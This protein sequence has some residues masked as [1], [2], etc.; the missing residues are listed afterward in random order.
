MSHIIIRLTE[1]EAE[2]L[3][4]AVNGH[5]AGGEVALESGIYSD[6]YVMEAADRAADKIAAAM[7]AVN[8]RKKT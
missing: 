1:K 8:K 3:L 6:R 5:E 7:A 2:A 4:D